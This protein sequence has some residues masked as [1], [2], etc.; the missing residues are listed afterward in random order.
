[1]GRGG[2]VDWWIGGKV[3]TATLCLLLGGLQYQKQLEKI[4]YVSTFQEIMKRYEQHKDGPPALEIAL[5]QQNE[6][7][8]QGGGNGIHRMGH[9][10]D[11][12]ED[13]EYFNEVD[14]DEED[15]KQGNSG[16][17]DGLSALAGYGE[18]DDE[19]SNDNQE[20]TVPGTSSSSSSLEEEEEEFRLP[21]RKEKGK[22][23]GAGG[24]FGGKSDTPRP[25]GKKKKR[26]SLV[27]EDMGDTVRGMLMENVEGNEEDEDE[28]EDDMQVAVGSR[29]RSLDEMS[30]DGDV[31]R[32]EEEDRMSVSSV[33]LEDDEE[34]GQA[35]M[36]HDGERKKARREE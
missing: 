19:G 15:G 9:G 6:M 34:A 18:D 3:L 32:K 26:A 7:D 28:G 12:E 31:D 5:A 22:R 24:V 13:D 20:N 14:D 35:G 33:E 36:E 1:M 23:D 16:I 30:Q 21:V 11:W 10:G 17:M 2:L 27:V 8:I 4:Q 29:K 25:G